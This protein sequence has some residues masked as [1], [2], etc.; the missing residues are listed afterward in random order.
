M[1]CTKYKE[2]T[3]DT[4]GIMM[5]LRHVNHGQTLEGGS[6]QD[7]HDDIRDYNSLH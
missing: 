6:N 2:L 3:L 7:T 4:E 1:S 5:N